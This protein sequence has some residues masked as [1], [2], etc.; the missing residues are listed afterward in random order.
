M[1]TARPVCSIAIRF[2]LLLALL[3]AALFVSGDCAR[4]AEKVLRAGAFAADITPPEY[5]IS[6]NG[7]MADRQATNVHDPLHARCLVLDN[8]STQIAIVVCDCCMIPREPLD[9]AKRL[10]AK[11]TGLRKTTSWSRPRTHTT[12]RRWGPYSKANRTRLTQQFFVEQIAKGIAGATS[13]SS[14]LAS[15]GASAPMPGPG[16]QPPL[17]NEA[18]HHA[19]GAVWPAHRHGEDEP[20]LNEPEPDRAGRPDRSRRLGDLGSG[21]MAG[22]LPC[23]PITVCTTSAACGPLSA[24][25]FG[26]FAERIKH[27]LN[28]DEV[29]PAFVGIMSNGTSGDMQQHQLPT[30]RAPRRRA[31]EQIEIVAKS[32]ARNGLERDGQD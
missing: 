17:E 11:A 3:S 23:W 13:N 15:A 20:G 4:A 18:G 16:V 31:F 9:A 7:G 26:E 24:D 25:Y 32:V 1:F 5:P 8:G 28:A 10:A 22:R 27:L 30:G 29:N 14:R 12:A 21:P 6:V 2:G 19:A